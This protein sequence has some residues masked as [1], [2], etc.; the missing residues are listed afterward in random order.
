MV[1][2]FVLSF[3]FSQKF[4]TPACA[5]AGTAYYDYIDGDKYVNYFNKK[6]IDKIPEDLK[7]V[8]IIGA[9]VAKK[10]IKYKVT[11]NLNVMYELGSDNDSSE[12]VNFN[13]NFP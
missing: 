8:A 12:T 3:C 13:L 2:L 5:A 1:S 7:D 10:Q 4:K 11:N 6:Y 9:M